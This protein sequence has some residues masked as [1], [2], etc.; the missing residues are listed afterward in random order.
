M[1]ACVQGIHIYA[2]K[3]FRSN[4]LAVILLKSIK[5]VEEINV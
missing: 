5:N 4:K 2:R 3:I 1:C